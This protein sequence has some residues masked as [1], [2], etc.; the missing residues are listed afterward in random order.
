MN[1]RIINPLLDLIES[2]SEVVKQLYPA[3]LVR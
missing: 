2:A 3:L 1:G